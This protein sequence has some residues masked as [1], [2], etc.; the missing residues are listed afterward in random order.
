M[1]FSTA[2]FYATMLDIGLRR[3]HCVST[4]E[5]HIKKQ[6]LMHS[7][8]NHSIHLYFLQVF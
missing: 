5:I 4:D 6:S 8:T 2:F 7:I 3:N 1:S